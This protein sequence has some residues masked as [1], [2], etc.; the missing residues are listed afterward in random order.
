MW[1]DYYYYD[2]DDDGDH[3]DDDAEDTFFECYDGNKRRKAQK[4]SIKKGLLPIAW[5]PSR[6]WNWCMSE[7]ERD[8][9]I[10]SMKHGLFCVW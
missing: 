6:W 10:V 5:H 4:T 9:K 7:D 1:F 2:D 8:R 3:W